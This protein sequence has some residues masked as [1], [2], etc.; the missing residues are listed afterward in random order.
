MLK[1]SKGFLLLHMNKILESNIVESYL[2]E[3]S[4]KHIFSIY[5]QSIWKRIVYNL[6][7]TTCNWI[8]LCF[9]NHSLPSEE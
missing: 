4:E 6:R 3:K 7:D 1:H 9:L 2:F 8:I 5:R